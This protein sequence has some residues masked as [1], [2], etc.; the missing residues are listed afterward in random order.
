MKDELLD[1]LPRLGNNKSG[2]AS[3]PLEEITGRFVTIPRLG[4]RGMKMQ[5]YSTVRTSRR[6]SRQL[7]AESCFDSRIG[8]W[9]VQLKT[10]I[11]MEDQPN[12]CDEKPSSE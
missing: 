10:K 6:L 9:I 3:S 2:R 5:S 8:I 7:G 12:A 1:C 4:T 11:G